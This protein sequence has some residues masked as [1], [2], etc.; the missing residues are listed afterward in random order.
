[1]GIVESRRR[2][3]FLYCILAGKEGQVEY[4][5]RQYPQLA[6]IALYSGNTNPMCRAAF[7]GRKNVIA[8]LLKH[9]ADINVSSGEGNTP[10]MWAAWKNNVRLIDFLVISGAKIDK[11]N[12]EGLNA[13]DIAV[14]RMNY[15]SAR[16]LKRQGLQPKEQ[17]FYENRMFTPFDI[18]LFL[19]Y[20]EEDREV[21]TLNVF[22]QKAKKEEEEK[23]RQ[24]LVVDPREGWGKYIKRVANFKDPPMV[25]REELPANRQPH[26]SF[27]GKLSCYLNGV[28]PY[29]P[30]SVRKIKRRDLEA[31]GAGQGKSPGIVARGLDEE[32]KGEIPLPSYPQYKEQQKAQEVVQVKV[33]EGERQEA[34][35]E[36]VLEL[37]EDK[38]ADEKKMENSEVEE[39][40]YREKEEEAPEE[41]DEIEK[42]KLESQEEEEEE[43]EKKA[44]EGTFEE[45]E[46]NNKSELQEEEGKQHVGDE[47]K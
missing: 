28:S 31:D 20:L 18:E 5:L 14:C 9:N 6:N 38:A 23:R 2:D 29:P 36:L 35:E 12:V 21:D 11:V 44:E 3:A 7:L 43:E 46:I 15:G 1:M 13:L 25:P 45:I 19:S 22:F 8:L 10:L 33:E 16:Y 39:P 41:E 32:S 47:A 30:D 27:Y 4:M 42:P 40:E 17:D 24:D 26:R 34:V 37:T